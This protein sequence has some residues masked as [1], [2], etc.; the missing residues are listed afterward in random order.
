MRSGSLFRYDTEFGT[1]YG[2][3]GNV[4][5]YTQFGVAS[6]DG[7]RSATA[8]ISLQL[9]TNS[10]GQADTVFTA[11]QGVVQAAICSALE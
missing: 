3:T 5:G 8:S 11:L 2:H 10:E 1:L 9:N 7:Q 6:P 4:F